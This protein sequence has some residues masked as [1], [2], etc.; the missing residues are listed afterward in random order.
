MT[1]MLVV[2]SKFENALYHA[3]GKTLMNCLRELAHPVLLQV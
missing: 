2:V 1:L 3:A